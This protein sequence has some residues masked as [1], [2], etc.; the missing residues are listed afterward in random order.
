MSGGHFND[1]GYIYHQVSQF[2][3]ELE[4]EINN[5]GKERNDTGYYGIDYYPKHSSEVIEYLEEQVHF[6][7]KMA[8]IMR[9]IDFLYSGDHGEDSFMDRVMEVERK[10]GT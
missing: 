1:N 5:N 10:Y 2:A 7:H 3:Y 8:D 4:E 6:I 9:H